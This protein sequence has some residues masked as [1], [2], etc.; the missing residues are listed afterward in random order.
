MPRIAFGIEY[1]G[2]AYRGW[3]TQAH[4]VSLQAE[5]ERALSAVADH[6]VE[7]TAA[8][9]T[10]AGV[11]ATMQV[12]HF[13]TQADRSAHGWM[14]GANTLLPRD[15]GVLWVR[16]VPDDFHA[17]YS[18]QARSYR[19]VIQNRRSRASLWRD[20]A[21]W[22]RH[23]LDAAS[24]HD[25][26]QPLIGEHDFT[27]YRAAECQS[28]TPLR[29][30]ETI[31]VARGEEFVYIDITA[32]AFLHHMVRNIAG[33]LLAVGRGDQPIEWPSQVLKAQDRRLAGV[34]APP[35]GLYFV[36]VR[37]APELALP[38]SCPTGPD[39]VLMPPVSH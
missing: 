24:M 29:R 14:L 27:S 36:G 3:Q 33:T 10:D 39:R 4:A 21:C 20:R 38:S 16:A 1:D 12:A 6:P 11:H 8:G 37:Y 19:Y 31:A 18:A 22:E 28:R 34:T 23:A 30:V 7:V 5:V 9:R 35:Q 25:A 17:R 2:T 15:I 32:N 26:A 13:D